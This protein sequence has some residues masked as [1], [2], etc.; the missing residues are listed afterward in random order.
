V[1][2]IL[3]PRSALGANGLLHQWFGF[4]VRLTGK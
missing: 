3:S 4:A 2:A 1:P